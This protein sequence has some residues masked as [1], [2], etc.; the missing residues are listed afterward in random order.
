MISTIS[1][2]TFVN[3]ANSRVTEVPLAHL[4][5]QVFYNVLEKIPQLSWVLKESQALKGASGA[6]AWQ[7][8]RVFLG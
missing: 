3:D 1:V 6:R 2:W 4:V 7:D 5:H 8:L